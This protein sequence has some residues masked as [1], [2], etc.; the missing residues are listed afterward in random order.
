M[1]Q[2]APRGKSTNDAIDVRKYPADMAGMKG[3]LA[4]FNYAGRGSKMSKCDWH[5]AYKHVGISQ[6]QWKYQWFTYAG[7]SVSKVEVALDTMSWVVGAYF[8]EKCA[9]F[10][11]KSSPGI[12]CRCARLPV[13][14]VRLEMGLPALV[15]S[16]HLDDLIMGGSK[17]GWSIVQGVLAK[18]GRL[19]L[20]GVLMEIS[21]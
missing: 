13:E 14:I 15:A 19:Q 18:S 16:M 3:V 5:D 7:E 2:S 9:T 1:D 12:F 10:G 4:L 6:S 8:C 20:Q 21:M 17:V 11:C